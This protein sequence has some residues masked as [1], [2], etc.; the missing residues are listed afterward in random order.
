MLSDVQDAGG[1][2]AALGSGDEQTQFFARILKG[3]FGYSDDKNLNFDISSITKSYGHHV[4]DEKGNG[5]HSISELIEL[6]LK[7]IGITDQNIISQ[8]KDYVASQIDNKITDPQ[9]KTAIMKVASD[10]IENDLQGVLNLISIDDAIN[11]FALDQA[12]S[13]TTKLAEYASPQWQ[14]R[15]KAA[16]LF[17]IVGDDGN[18]R[19]LTEEQLQK[20]GFSKQ[21][22][23]MAVLFRNT[24]NTRPDDE[25]DNLDLWSSNHMALVPQNG[26]TTLNA[27]AIHT[28]NAKRTGYS[29]AIYKIIYGDKN[30]V[31]GQ[32]ATNNAVVTTNDETNV[33]DGNNVWDAISTMLNETT[34][35]S[36]MAQQDPELAQ[37]LRMVY[38][39]NGPSVKRRQFFI[40]NPGM[41]EDLEPTILHYATL[42]QM[43]TSYISNQ[44]KLNAAKVIR[45]AIASGQ[46]QEGT[47]S[48]GNSELVKILLIYTANSMQYNC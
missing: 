35:L 37:I 33:V 26:I 1:I 46:L 23:S 27:G 28:R 40:D 44:D 30:N 13:N 21:I 18:K 11:L 14:D 32:Q 29:S 3:F 22:A 16:A 19:Y 34:D 15:L 9:N 39:A 12:Q 45:K 4:L 8:Y 42:G 24:Y 31:T 48:D 20:Y 2:E 25:I 10:Y 5:D 38:Q 43:G 47:F 36:N 7:S 6:R 17:Q 41:L